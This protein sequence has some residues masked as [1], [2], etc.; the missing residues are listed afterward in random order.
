MHHQ[1]RSPSL[2]LFAAV[3]G[4]GAIRF[5]GDVPRGALCACFCPVCNSPLVSKQGAVNAW[6]FAHEAGQERPECPVGAANLL[7]RLVAEL[8]LSGEWSPTLPRYE[9][10]IQVANRFGTEAELVEIEVQANGQFH[11]CTP[12]PQAKL[13]YIVATIALASG[14]QVDIG[15]DLDGQ[16]MPS[17]DF[18]DPDR[19][20]LMVKLPPVSALSTMA[21]AIAFVKL[22]ATMKWVLLPE[23]LTAERAAQQRCSERLNLAERDWQAR[24][25]AKKAVP[26]LDHSA[27][28]L[29]IKPLSDAPPDWPP[30]IRQKTS[31]TAWLFDDGSGLLLYRLAVGS[32]MGLARLPE[33][34][35][36]KE[37]AIRATAW[38]DSNTMSMVVADWQSLIPALNKIPSATL[39]SSDLGE[40]CAFL[41]RQQP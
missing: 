16:Q 22:R 8:L 9:R 25:A 15:V 5:P 10:S 28:P 32:S 19:G 4:I 7:R 31:A 29:S 27:P 21:D 3:D 30:N 38:P 14:T 17:A 13:G 34:P 41:R 40:L 33:R 37:S 26:P 12:P 6:H 39:S 23:A 24:Q 11:L 2:R 20:L 36:L 35:L 1:T 18:K